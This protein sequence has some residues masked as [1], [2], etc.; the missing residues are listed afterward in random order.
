LRKKIIFTEGRGIP[1]MV[2]DLAYWSN[3]KRYLHVKHDIPL[4][5]VN[6]PPHGFHDVHMEKIT[7]S[8]IRKRLQ[9]E[10]E[11]LREAQSERSS[12]PRGWNPV[13][14]KIYEPYL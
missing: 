1:C 8:T 5:D 14:D 6:I 4:A 3:G 7:D 2:G 11:L 13:S 10:Q 12:S 9:E